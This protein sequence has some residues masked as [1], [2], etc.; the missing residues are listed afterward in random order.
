M[1]YV[2]VPQ[3]LLYTTLHYTHFFSS[4]TIA[5]SAISYIPLVADPLRAAAHAR[6][7]DTVANNLSVAPEPF[8][9]PAS[10]SAGGRFPGDDAGG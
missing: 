7:C 5:A 9:P 6:G 3:P 2:T 8:L 1:P 4:G 10:D